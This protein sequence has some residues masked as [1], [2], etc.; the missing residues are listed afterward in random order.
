MIH[1]TETIVNK[2]LGLTFIVKVLIKVTVTKKV[3][4]RLDYSRYTVTKANWKKQNI[5]T[6]LE[7]LRLKLS[8]VKLSPSQIGHIKVDTI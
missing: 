8:G 2:K 4:Q 6:H 7:R 3:M 1:N 5:R